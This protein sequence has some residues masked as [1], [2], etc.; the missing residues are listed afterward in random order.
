MK[1]ETRKT[2]NLQ[3]MIWTIAKHFSKLTK[4]QEIRDCLDKSKSIKVMFYDCII[5]E[6]GVLKPGVAASKCN[7][8]TQEADRE[9]LA[10]VWSPPRILS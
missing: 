7:P 8:S 6:R 1:L 2:T 3:K 5:T 4:C 10:G 9:W